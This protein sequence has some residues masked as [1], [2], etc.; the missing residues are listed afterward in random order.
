M[1]E[2]P[3]EFNFPE[4]NDILFE[5]IKDI[6]LSE[7]LIVCVLLGNSQNSSSALHGTDIFLE[8]KE[9]QY[10]IAD[11]LDKE[12]TASGQCR[13]LGL[14]LNYTQEERPLLTF[15]GGIHQLIHGMVVT[16][17]TVPSPSFHATPTGGRLAIDR[18]KA[19][20]SLEI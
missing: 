3:E 16:G 4:I 19:G 5:V 2:Y 12:G 18:F 14:P 1:Q 10:D 17:S 11:S 7:T 6:T 20:H 13:T 8:S 9:D 15:L